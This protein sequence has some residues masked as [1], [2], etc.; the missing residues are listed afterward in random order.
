MSA[1][2]IL[3]SYYDA[4]ARYYDQAYEG[5]PPPWVG[6][7][8]S[9]LQHMLAGR[10]VL[11]VACGTGH[12]TRPAAG[13]AASVVAIDAIPAMRELAEAKLADLPGVRFVEADAYDLS[14][15]GAGFTGGLAMQWLSHVPAER[16]DEF[17][18][19]WHA[20]M[21]AGAQ[22]FLGDNQLTGAWVQKLRRGPGP[23]TYE[24]RELPDGSSFMIVK[25]YFTE[26]E[27]RALIEPYGD[28]L[29]LT[30]GDWWWW[31]GYQ[32]R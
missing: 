19:G 9:D 8:V 26:A 32:L 16:R 7:M 1:D 11:E 23:D 18:T 31:L 4:R 6:E 24:P 12:W 22:I 21:S 3:R 10:R 20:Q 29:T 17:F 5:A 13:V 30:M 28:V 2:A 15:L 27:L 25:N 14:G